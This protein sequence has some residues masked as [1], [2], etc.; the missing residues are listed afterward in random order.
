MS[1][2]TDFTTGF[3]DKYNNEIKVG[4][5]LFFDNGSKYLV[6]SENNEFILKNVSNKNIPLILLSKVT[7]GNLLSTAI[8]LS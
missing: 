2:I 6:L 5:Y 1:K 4:D 8:I 3:Y 7:Y